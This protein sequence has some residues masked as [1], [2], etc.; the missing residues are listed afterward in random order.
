[1]DFLKTGFLTLDNLVNKFKTVNWEARKLKVN[2]YEGL[3]LRSLMENNKN[4]WCP[5]RYLD[6]AYHWLK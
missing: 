1:M 6:T 2:E 3:V 5:T 4:Q